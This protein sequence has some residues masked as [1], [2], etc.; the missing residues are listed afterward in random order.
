MIPLGVC[1]FEVLAPGPAKHMRVL[2]IVS[3]VKAVKHKKRS[4]TF[5]DDFTDK[6]SLNIVLDGN[7][8]NEH[9]PDSILVMDMGG[10][11]HLES[12]SI[13]VKYHQRNIVIVVAARI[14]LALYVLGLFWWLLHHYIYIYLHIL[15]KAI[16]VGFP[17]MTYISSW[18]LQ[19]M[20]HPVTGLLRQQNSIVVAMC[21]QKAFSQQFWFRSQLLGCSGSGTISQKRI[22][23]ET[24]VEHFQ[25]RAAFNGK[26]KQRLIAD[27]LAAWTFLFF[28]FQ[29]DM[30]WM[31][32]KGLGKH[33]PCQLVEV[34]FF[35]TC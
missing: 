2:Y 20:N 3:W 21:N 5:D 29:F 4:G 16:F 24:S 14:C 35:D 17:H 26:K 28:Q 10:V 23:D 19:K 7:E 9:P 11:Q 18:D 8:T 30:S 31:V 15:L 1:R 6:D 12:P 33:D 22:L 32:R 34:F 13:L 25:I 27:T